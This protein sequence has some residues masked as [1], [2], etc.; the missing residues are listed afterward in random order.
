MGDNKQ[1][2]TRVIGNRKGTKCLPTLESHE[3]DFYIDNDT[4]LDGRFSSHIASA[5]EINVVSMYLI[6]PFT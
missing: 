2:E 3:A 4:I 5:N 6:R 1:L